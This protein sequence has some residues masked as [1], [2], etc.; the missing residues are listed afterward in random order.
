MRV[1]A[2]HQPGTYRLGLASVQENVR[3]FDED[4]AHI[5][6]GTVVVSEPPSLVPG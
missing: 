3:W 2:P 6:T 1:D 5:W 4:P